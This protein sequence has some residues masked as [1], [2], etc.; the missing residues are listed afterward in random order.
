MS[1][2]GFFRNWLMQHI[3]LHSHDDD[4]SEFANGMTHAVGAVLCIV[5]LIAMVVKTY[6]WTNGPM[7]FGAVLYG[8]SMLLL[9]SSSSIYHLVKGPVLKRVMRIMDHTSIYLLI[10]GT[11]TPV[12]LYIQSRACITV[13]AVVWGLTAIGIVFTLLFWG[14]FGFLHVLFYLV[15]GWLVMLVW[16]ELVEY[17]PADFLPWALAGG[18]TYTLGT[19]VYA[20]KKIPYYHAI[21]HLFVLGG[22]ACFFF[23]IYFHLL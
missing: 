17:I 10:A 11:Y 20:A 22:S 18:L 15:M 6:P 13:L 4:R 9:Y 21:W 23:G 7:T 1:T 14:R 2:S 8:F 16:G 5:A 19:V 3:T 12:M